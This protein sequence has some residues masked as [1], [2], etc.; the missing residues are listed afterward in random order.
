MLLQNTTSNGTTTL[1]Y[2]RALYFVDLVGNSVVL[3]V[4]LLLLVLV[5][6]KNCFN[7]NP[8]YHKGF[9][10]YAVLITRITSAVG[11]IVPTVIPALYPYR[12]YFFQ[13]IQVFFQYLIAKT[14][15]IAV[16]SWLHFILFDLFN[17]FPFCIEN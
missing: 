12:C 1:P 8:V 4:A 6:W 11:L 10:L 14:N 15:T 13:F 3:L 9:I 5:A 7:R 2:S 17:S 16:A